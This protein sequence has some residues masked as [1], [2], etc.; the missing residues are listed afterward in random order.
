MLQGV[1]RIGLDKHPRLAG[2]KTD[3]NAGG[4]D[5]HQGQVQPPIDA[6]G[7]IIH[8]QSARRPSMFDGLNLSQDTPAE[9]G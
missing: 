5:I 1:Q 2:L 9:I 3:V 8:T 4:G 7:N 6:N